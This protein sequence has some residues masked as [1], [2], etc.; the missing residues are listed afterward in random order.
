[1]L[2]LEV[3]KSRL[4][5]RGFSLVIAKER[6]VVFET[7]EPGVS[8]FLKAIDKFGKD[9]LVGSSIA[10]KVVG[11]AAAMLCVRCGVEA[12][13]AVIL[14]EGGKNLLE[15]NGI[16]IQFER[17]VPNILNRQKTGTCPFE[18]VVATISN[19]E[20]AYEKLKSCIPK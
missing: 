17:L 19:A 5:E 20:E 4:R 6:K 3:A 9:G 2:D 1:M 12:V 16:S 14:S 15:K 18:Q 13:Y 11:R 10:D 7:T 8:G